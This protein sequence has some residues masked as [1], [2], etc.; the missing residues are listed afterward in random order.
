MSSQS[1]NLTAK[2]IVLKGQENYFNWSSTMTAYFMMNS[3]WKVV[4]GG[5]IKLVPTVIP[6]VDAV[7][8][9]TKHDIVV[10]MQKPESNNQDKI[11]R[12]EENDMHS[13]H[14]CGY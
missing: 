12:W 14:V 1:N 10:Q 5:S 3:L 7:F 8:G 6:K 11:D 2:L 9:G 4:N 13:Q